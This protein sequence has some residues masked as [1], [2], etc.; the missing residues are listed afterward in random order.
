MHAPGVE[1]NVVLPPIFIFIFTKE[2]GRNERMVIF[3]EAAMQLQI[4]SALSDL[5]FN[6]RE[7]SLLELSWTRIRIGLCRLILQII[8]YPNIRLRKVF[9][10][11]D[12]PDKKGGM[13]YGKPSAA[14]F[15]FHFSVKKLQSFTYVEINCNESRNIDF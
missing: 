2:R 4:P 15:I 6:S 11:E 7:I 8:V 3:Q 14:V 9:P 5:S 10:S 13:G 12:W 1:F